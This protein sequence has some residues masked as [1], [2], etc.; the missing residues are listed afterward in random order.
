[1]KRSIYKIVA[2]FMVVATMG[3][4]TKGFEEMNENPNAPEGVPTAYLMTNAQ[5]SLVSDVRDN[6]LNGRMGLLYSQYWSQINYTDESR[7]LPR[8]NVTNSY[9]NV[10]YRDLYDLQD[11]INKCTES[12]DDYAISGYPANQIA[13]AT[14]LKSYIFH[15]MT[16]IWGD[17]PYFGALQ[18]VENTRPVYDD[19]QAIYDDLLVQ[20]QNASDMIDVGQPGIKGDIIY[21]GDMAKWKKFANSLIMRIALRKG[22]VATATAAYPNAFS[23]NDDNAHFQYAPSGEAVN[24]IFVDFINGN[25]IEKDFAVSKT[26]TDYMNANNDPR[27]PFYAS[28]SSNGYMGV[29][30]GLNNENAPEEYKLGRSIQAANIYAADAWTPLMNYDEVLFIMAEI[31]NDETSFRDA[32]KASALNWGASEAD[33]TTLSAG[34]AFDGLESIITEKWVANY[35]QGFQGWSEYRRTGFPSFIDLPADGVEVG[36]DIGS[37]K[38]PNRRAYPTDEEQLN[39]AN[40]TEAVNGLVDQVGQQKTPMFW[41]Q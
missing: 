11:I 9:F 1:M 30:Y 36:V 33:A 25:R 38:V 29:T 12:P 18:G 34:I 2:L 26:I 4:C 37:L 40:Y 20:L 3:S 28:E 41:Q 7:Y 5:Y 35:M 39:K 27:L 21:D 22:D 15:I 13:S 6:W 19:S 24:P 8:V 14:I 23:S 31:N 16:D 10:L 32:I 17:I